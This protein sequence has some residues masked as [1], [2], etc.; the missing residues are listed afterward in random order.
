MDIIEKI[1]KALAVHPARILE[2]AAGLNSAVAVI[3]RQTP[4]GPQ[5][6]FIERSTNE[7][8]PWSGQIAFPGGKS[9]RGDGSLRQTAE[10]ETWE[11]LGVDLTAARFLGRL[12]DVAPAGLSVTVSCFVYAVG[13]G[14]ELHLN[15]SE[16]ASAFWTPFCEICQPSRFVKIK[17][18][19]HDRLRSF[20]A[21]RLSG[22]EKP[23][24]WG[25]SY[26]M[27]RNLY[28]VARG[29]LPPQLT[30]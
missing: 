30:T 21:I 26:T 9:E 15:K 18:S 28:K 1:G 14:Q 11:E 17:V 2:P 27:F 19:V 3:L 22:D 8:D 23:P 7:N 24:L 6:L 12:D 16:V 20:P 13:Q 10:R 4:T 29:S 5:I 25:I